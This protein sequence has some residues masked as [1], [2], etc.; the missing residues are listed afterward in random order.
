MRFLI[1][2]LWIAIG[3]LYGAA[4]LWL[5]GFS[6]ISSWWWLLC[7]IVT[8]VLFDLFPNWWAPDA[9]GLLY[10][11][12]TWAVGGVVT[13]VWAVYQ[14]PIGRWY[15]QGPTN[16]LWAALVVLL[17]VVGWVIASLYL[18]LEHALSSDEFRDDVHGYQLRGATP[19]ETITVLIMAFIT[20]C[21]WSMLLLP[22]SYAHD[23]QTIDRAVYALLFAY[24]MVWLGKLRATLRYLHNRDL[25]NPDY[26]NAVKQNKRWSDVRSNQPRSG[27]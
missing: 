12:G 19:L 21:G 23:T 17:T 1:S 7:L 16:S 14:E 13:Y 8:A 22:L 10:F 27:F 2:T 4:I 18:P 15:A 20:L 3:G 24:I 11:L 9:S 25:L 26:D 5:P 6:D